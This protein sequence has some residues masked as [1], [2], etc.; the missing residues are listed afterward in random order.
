MGPAEICLDDEQYVSICMC[1][2]PRP[3]ASRI[4]EE[5]GRGTNK[6]SLSP[7]LGN[8]ICRRPRLQVVSVA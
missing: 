1:Y 8:Q 3:T 5:P 6:K 7:F 2:V 4:T